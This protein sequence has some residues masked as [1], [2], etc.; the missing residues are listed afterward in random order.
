[1]AMNWNKALETWP[2][3]SHLV[4]KLANQI[5]Q[6]EMERRSILPIWNTSSH[7]TSVEF[8]GVVPPYEEH[9]WGYAEFSAR[10]LQIEASFSA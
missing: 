6:E 4:G 1:M 9:V 3:Y 7:S 5:A 8:F 2:W 10:A